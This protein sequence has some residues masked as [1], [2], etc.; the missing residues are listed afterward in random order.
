M[1]TP[2]T[3][4]ASRDPVEQRRYSMRDSIWCALSCASVLAREES[5]AAAPPSVHAYRVTW[6]VAAVFWR[7]LPLGADS[8]IFRNSYVMLRYGKPRSVEGVEARG[9]GASLPLHI[10]YYILTS[11]F[12]RV[13]GTAVRLFTVQH[14]PQQST[15]TARSALQSKHSYRRTCTVRTRSLTYSCTYYSCTDTVQYAPS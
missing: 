10:A 15:C 9:T 7:G 5:L 8:F 1:H 2:T 14:N 13:E 4:G 12:Y 11:Y 3:Q 6:A